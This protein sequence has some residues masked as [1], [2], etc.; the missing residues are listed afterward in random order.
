MTEAHLAEERASLLAAVEADA[1]EILDLARWM[2]GSPEL[3]LAE[4]ETSGGPAKFIE[5]Y[6]SAHYLDAYTT[7]SGVDLQDNIPGFDHLEGMIVA[8]TVDDATHPD[9]QVIGGTITLQAPGNLVTAGPGYQAR[10]QTLPLEGGAPWG[11]QQGVMKRYHRIFVRLVASILPYINGVR[12]SDR[13][14][15]TPMDTREPSSTLEDARVNHD[16]WD[17]AGQVDIV[18]DAPFPT[19]IVGVF[20]EEKANRR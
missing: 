2:A 3:S 5:R 20:G 11:S 18:Q 13:S 8:V 9:V 4:Y 1:P 12:P 7:V 19:Q 6:S 17:R 16:G 10:A 14:P 15:S